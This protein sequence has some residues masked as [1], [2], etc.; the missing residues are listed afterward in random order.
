MNQN[1]TLQDVWNLY[2]DTRLAKE[3]NILKEESRFNKH[4]YS[5]WGNTEL[6]VIR[7][8][9]ILV[10]RKSLFQKKLSE[11]TVRNCL[12]LLRCL[13]NRAK[14]YELYDGYIP[15]FEMP[16]I[17]N[18]RTRFLTETEAQIL[19][20]SLQMRSELWHDITL[21]ALHTGMRANEIF[22]I[23]PSSINL[24]HKLVTLYETK[25]GT[26]RVL[27]LNSTAL[28]IS[29]KYLV[30]EQRYL[31]SNIHLTSVSKVFRQTVNDIGLNKNI[32][33]NKD[34]IV[35]HSLRHTFASWLVQRGIPLQVVSQLLGH[36]D[37]KMTMRYAHLAPEQGRNAVNVLTTIIK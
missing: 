36:K 26:A 31:F 11:K 35:F 1:C 25:N 37:L 2:K 5:Y 24:S 29:E 30:K 27:P 19:L 20:Q 33:N 28:A 3:I 34:K 18:S 23:V 14:K 15:Y 13:F 10:F 9:D 8:K 32:T 22:S 7:T 12:S 21:F 6:S 4:I 16:L 17:N